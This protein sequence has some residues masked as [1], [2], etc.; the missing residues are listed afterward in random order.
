M[1]GMQDMMPMMHDRLP[2]MNAGLQ[3]LQSKTGSEF[4]I[5]F[6]SE[7]SHHHAMASIDGAAGADVPE[8]QT[9]QTQ[10]SAGWSQRASGRLQEGVLSTAHESGQAA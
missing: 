10:A 9:A 6:P 3:D 4:E 5:A 2:D 8:H 1:S 7:M